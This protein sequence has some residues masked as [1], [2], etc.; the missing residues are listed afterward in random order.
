MKHAV[1][2]SGLYVTAVMMYP[3][4]EVAI[5]LV[6]F[7]G[8]HVVENSKVIHRYS[9]MLR[10]WFRVCLSVYSF[11]LWLFSTTFHCGVWLCSSAW[12][13]VKWKI[14]YLR[15]IFSYICLGS[16]CFLNMFMSSLYSV[17]LYIVSGMHLCLW[18]RSYSLN[19]GIP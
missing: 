12:A 10:R 6:L 15:E 8:P 2:T 1:N 14:W 7:S 4:P 19:V 5:K 17:V 18:R 13:V 16:V 3:V 11:P 9:Y